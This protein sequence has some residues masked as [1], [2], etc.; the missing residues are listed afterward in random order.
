MAVDYRA[1]GDRRDPADQGRA[2]RPA[3]SSPRHRDGFV[4]ERF[5]RL[6]WPSLMTVG[7]MIVLLG[8]GTWQVKRLFWKE[9]LLAQ[10]D[11]AEAADPVPL[12]A[13]PSRSPLSPFMKVSAAGEFLPDK[14]ALYG[15]EVRTIATGPAMGARMIEPLREA[16]GDTI[17]VDRGWVPVS[18]EAPIDQPNGTV[19][20]SGYLRPGDA[21]HWFSVRDDPAGRRFF[22]LDPK[23]IGD[24]IGLP[25]VRPFVLVV[26]AAHPGPSGPL[27]GPDLTPNR[28]PDPAR[29]LPRPPNSHLSYAVTWYGLALA[30]LAIFIVWARRGPLA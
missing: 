16:S 7:M 25:D 2:D 22:T 24:A 11:R 21:S 13:Q 9:A 6:L 28:W 27:A 18:R 30:L 14:A 1:S 26:L 5:R 10:I 29:H 4:T 23:I 19:T 15:A 12:P 8:L 3:I 20:I 17:L